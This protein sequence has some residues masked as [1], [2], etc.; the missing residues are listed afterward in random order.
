MKLFGRSL[1][2]YWDNFV[3]LLITYSAI[4]IPLE[5]ALD[6]VSKSR[7]VLTINTITV[8][9]FLLDLIFNFYHALKKETETN[10]NSKQNSALTRKQ[11]LYSYLKTWFIIDLI[12]IIPY[13]L[14]IQYSFL[15][16]SYEYLALAR[17]LRLLR[18]LK[19]AQFMQKWGQ[20]EFSNQGVMR[21]FYFVYWTGLIAHWIALGWIY[22]GGVPEKINDLPIDPNEPFTL[23]NIALYWTITTLTT[24]GYG[25]IT[26]KTNIQR[27]YTMIVMIIG[28]GLYGYIIGNIANLLTNIDIAK[29]N[30]M[31]KMEKINTFMKY[32]RIP[33]ELQNR[34]NN[35]YTFL[36]ENRKGYDE[37]NIM[38][39]LPSS[40]RM[41]I[42]LY[43]N[44]DIFE[45]IPIFKEASEDLISELVLN[46][47][48]V[49]FTPGDYIF[50]KGDIGLNMYFISRGIVEVIDEDK[51]HV[52]AT[53]TDG[54]FFGEM[55]LVFSAPRNASIKALDYC[56]L[57]TLDKETFDKVIVNFPDFAKSIEEKANKRFKNHVT[58]NK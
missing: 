45:K 44:K 50:R 40:L 22:I 6:S 52:I 49:I 1:F 13:D 8:F 35:Y 26:P 38:D 4:I 31:Q 58:E 24:I 53:L 23:Y 36:W 25:D 10:A 33:V 34:I 47:K 32:R 55:A 48:P 2:F 37:S 11:R 41:K 19:I 51:E 28:A 17:T 21:L 27:M 7:T 57:Y 46:L 56:D 12:S 43:L 29:T 9:C 3:I 42:A 54:N 20:T 18:L 39:E 30:F 5:I 15:H 16:P 14:L